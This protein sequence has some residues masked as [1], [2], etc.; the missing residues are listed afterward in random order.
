MYMKEMKK[1]QKRLAN[2]L[3]FLRKQLLDMPEGNL[4]CTKN[5][6]YTKWYR[7]DGKKAVYIR[8]KDRVLAEAL[9]KKK[10][11]QLQ[12]EEVIQEK[13]RID[14]FLKSF[15]KKPQ[16]LK[17]FLENDD[18]RLLLSMG[19]VQQDKT[20]WMKESYEKNRKNS[21]YLIHKT[22]SGHFVRSKSEV[23]IANS[24][25]IYQVPYRYECALHMGDI[26]VYPD[27]TILHPETGDILYWEHFGMMDR[28]DYVEKAFN[29]LKLYTMNKIIP[30]GNLIT[31]YETAAYPL[32][33]GKV[34]SLIH[35]Y[36]L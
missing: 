27:F 26:T 22:L 23:I 11:Y 9:A 33:S 3:A 18:Y 16:P 17:K 19:R 24:L 5:G 13:Q 25:F 29:K 2:Q 1:E 10:F 32:D 20:S 4:I 21:E 12:L 31:T 35:E 15:E 6:K 8:K 28:A 14:R 34:D 30:M 36:F 7:S